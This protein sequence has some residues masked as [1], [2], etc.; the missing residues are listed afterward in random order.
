[1]PS[2]PNSKSGYQKVNPEDPQTVAEIEDN[3]KAKVINIGNTQ[4]Q[5]KN[6]LASKLSSIPFLLS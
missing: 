5:I 2:P 1:M 3:L 4:H 6:Q